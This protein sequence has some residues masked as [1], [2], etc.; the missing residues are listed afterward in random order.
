MMEP[1]DRK[2]LNA[3][4]VTVGVIDERTQ[5]MQEYHEKEIAAVHHRVDEVRAEAKTEA[6][7]TGAIVGA[8]ISAA[9]FSATAALKG[10]FGS[11]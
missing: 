8:A 2:Q 11:P 6:R 9:F 4:A 3:I 5:L 10:L 7:R 1:E